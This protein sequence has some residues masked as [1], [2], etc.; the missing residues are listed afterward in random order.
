MLFLVRFLGGIAL[1]FLA[2]K[3]T[4]RWNYKLGAFADIVGISVALAVTACWILLCDKAT[5]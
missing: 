2:A 5:R 4:G 3:I 1:G